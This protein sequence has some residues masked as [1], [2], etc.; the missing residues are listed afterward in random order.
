M[1]LTVTNHNPQI[2]L[3]TH[4][5]L[6]SWR[7]SVEEHSA[8]GA[9]ATRTV[10]EVPTPDGWHIALAPETTSLRLTVSATYVN[11]T[12]RRILVWIQQELAV[13][14]ARGTLT[15]QAWKKGPVDDPIGRKVVTPL[16]HPLLVIQGSR[17]EVDLQFVD[18]T[19]V[20]T[21]LHNRSYWW[22]ILNLL[23]RRTQQFRVL[24]SLG[25]HPLVWY[26]VVP[27]VC[28][29]LPLVKPV[30][31]VMPADYGAIPYEN[32]LRGLAAKVHGESYGAVQSGLE[33]LMRIMLEPLDDDRYRRMLPGYVR[34]IREFSRKGPNVPPPLHHFRGVLAYASA[35]PAP[36]PKYW[37]P[38]CGL[39]RAM[40]ET[41]SL[42]F[43]PLMNSGEGGVLIQPG[44]QGRVANAVNVLY[45][46]SHLLHY[47]RIDVAKPVLVA[48]SP[49]ATCSRRPTGTRTVSADLCC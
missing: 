3:F 48:Y 31:L 24:A 32:N 11:G 22:Q 9:L 30:V 38:P 35:S 43:L 23:C 12:R 34:L 27:D 29:P 49:V 2:P 14:Q 33:I 44:L 36:E 39:E 46:H 45:T 13:N 8:A 20:Y 7:L 4:F 6:H 26:V 16:L 28:R 40:E 19:S 37:D 41:R 25:G 47:E 5:L 21:E 1:E 18:I 10:E 15:A 17:L 42:L